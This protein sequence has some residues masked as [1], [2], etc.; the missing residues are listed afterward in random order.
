MRVSAPLNVRGSTNIADVVGCFLH[1]GCGVHEEFSRCIILTNGE[2]LK[3]R[4]AVFLK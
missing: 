4:I 2:A 1:H 3:Q